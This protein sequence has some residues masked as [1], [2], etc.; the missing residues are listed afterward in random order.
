VPIRRGERSPI[1]INVVDRARAAVAAA[2]FDTRGR[3]GNVMAI[4]R[5]DLSFDAV[6]GRVLGA[7]VDVQRPVRPS[8][9]RA[10]GLA[11]CRV[12]PVLGG[13]FCLVEARYHPHPI[14][15]GPP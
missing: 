5:P 13:A 6:V 4:E 10:A 3:Q 1:V 14:A 2:G 12:K 8:P 9:V 11:V 7:V 15:G